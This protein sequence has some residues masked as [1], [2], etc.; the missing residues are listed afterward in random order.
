[1]GRK[2]AA[3]LLIDLKSRLELPE[4]SVGPTGSV[5]GSNLAR[6]EVREALAELGYGPEEIKGALERLSVEG[7]EDSVEE[8]LRGAL[9]ELA[10]R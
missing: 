4:L 7:D 10:S 6:T 9:R 5:P 3:R 1:V 8:L 2:T